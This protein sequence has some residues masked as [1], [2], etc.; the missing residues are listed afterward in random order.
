[1][2]VLYYQLRPH[3]FDFAI[4]N[5]A[6]Q[7]VKARSSRTGTSRAVSEAWSAAPH[8]PPAACAARLPSFSSG[9]IVDSKN[10][11]DVTPRSD[12]EDRRPV[13]DP[14]ARWANDV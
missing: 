3:G 6:L 2:E 7:K 13:H 1:M 12:E 5:A 9:E 4:A 11:P 14:E 10:T 8:D